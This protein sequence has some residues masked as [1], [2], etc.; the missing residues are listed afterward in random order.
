MGQNCH[1][2]CQACCHT[3][4]QCSPNPLP[5]IMAGMTEED[6]EP[7]QNLRQAELTISVVPVRAL[8]VGGDSCVCVCGGI[9]ACAQVYTLVNRYTHTCTHFLCIIRMKLRVLV[10]S[11]SWELP[12]ASC[13][14]TGTEPSPLCPQP[15]SL[16][17][18]GLL[19]TQPEG[20]ARPPSLRA[21]GPASSGPCES[22][23]SCLGSWGSGDRRLLGPRQ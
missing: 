16:G 23:G 10:P 22:E 8:C 14:S 7:T 5:H 17:T 4:K 13:R 11:G 6:A 21:E 12:R 18:P 9:C 15:G 1:I 20:I 3:P 2:Q 19:R